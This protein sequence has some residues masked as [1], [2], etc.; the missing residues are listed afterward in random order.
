MNQLFLLKMMLDLLQ[1]KPSKYK[2]DCVKKILKGMI[3][4]MTPA[5]PSSEFD[6]LERPPASHSLLDFE[7]EAAKRELQ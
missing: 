7:A 2:I 6:N 1:D 4:E 5:S 3:E